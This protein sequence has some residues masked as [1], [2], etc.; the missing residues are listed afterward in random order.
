MAVH[1]TEMISRRY[2]TPFLTIKLS[3]EEI[4]GISDKLANTA[5]L[6][7]FNTLCAPGQTEIEFTKEINEGALKA[8]FE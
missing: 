1:L 4:Q 5:A 6:V 3:S 2:Q 8:S 7:C